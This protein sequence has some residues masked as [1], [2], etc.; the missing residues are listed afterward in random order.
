MLEEAI[1][2][3][4][5]LFIWFVWSV[6]SISC[7]WFLW[8]KKQNKPN[9]PDEPARPATI[10]QTIDGTNYEINDVRRVS[11]RFH[12]I[13]AVTSGAWSEVWLQDV[14]SFLT[15]SLLGRSLASEVHLDN[16]TIHCL[17][18]QACIS[19]RIYK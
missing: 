1:H 19:S 12:E 3:Q 13:G 11:S 16:R 18:P 5:V 6:W 7:I 14:A 2:G 4:R 9:Q 10:Q 15:I 17:H 8:V